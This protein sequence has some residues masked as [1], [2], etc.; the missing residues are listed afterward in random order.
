MI[1][2]LTEFAAADI[3]SGALVYFEPYETVHHSNIAA[4]TATMR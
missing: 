1:P 4:V 3:A 2:Q